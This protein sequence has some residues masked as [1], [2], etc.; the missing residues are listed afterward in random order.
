MTRVGIDVSYFLDVA[1]SAGGKDI[2]LRIH[3]T[4]ENEPV[5][6]FEQRDDGVRGQHAIMP[7]RI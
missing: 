3:G 6:L 1:K 7:M 2:T 5:H 4:K